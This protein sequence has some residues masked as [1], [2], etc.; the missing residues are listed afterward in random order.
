MS[1][2]LFVVVLSIG[3]YFS[4]VSD[5]TSTQFLFVCMLTRSVY[6]YVY[7][8]LLFRS[9]LCSWFPRSGCSKET[10]F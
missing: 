6:S 3:I 10:I 1:L 5:D 7:P 9:L 4:D 2:T 8:D